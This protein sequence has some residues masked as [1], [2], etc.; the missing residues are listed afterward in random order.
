VT[1]R[2]DGATAALLEGLPEESQ[3]LSPER[4]HQGVGG[5]VLGLST[6]RCARAGKLLPPPLHL[7]LLML[8]RT[9]GPEA[10]GALAGA[11]DRWWGADLL[12]LSSEP[13]ARL[14]RR[15]L[16]IA[17]AKIGQPTV[18]DL[19][20][21]HQ[22]LVG[23]QARARAGR[24]T[25]VP[26]P[27]ARRWGVH[28][29]PAALVDQVTT[30]TLEPLLDGDITA[31]RICDPAMGG[32]AFLLGA[33]RFLAPRLA[34]S[35][36]PAALRSARRRIAER[37]LFGADRD[38]VAAWLTRMS[39]WLAVGDPTLTPRFCADHIL[40][41]DA[42]R[43]P[44]PELR[45]DSWRPDS[46]G[47]D[48]WAVLPMLFQR[49]PPGFDAVL[50]NP[51]F[52]GGKR[53]STEHGRAYR[54]VLRR[55][56]PRI[57]GNA[58]LAAHFLLR[59]WRLL[60]RGGSLGLVMPTT[61]GQGDTRSS[62]LASLTDGTLVRAVSR[63]PWPGAAGV[64]VSLIHLYA[65][66]WTGPR[67]L[68][69]AL[70]PHIASDLSARRWSEPPPAQPSHRRC[71][72]GCDLKGLGF[73]F[74]DGDPRSTPLSVREEILSQEPRYSAVIRPYMGAADLLSA[75]DLQPRA[76]VIALGRREEAEARAWPRVMEIV[77][78]RV[79][80][81][82]VHRSPEVAAWRWWWWWRDRPALTGAL[83]G[84]TRCLVVPLITK[85]LV[86]VWMPADI[87]FNHKLAVVTGADD[88]DFAVLQSG[89]HEAWARA[90]SS[91]RGVQINYTPSRCFRTFPF[92]ELSATERSPLSELGRALDTERI[93]QM[94]DH[95]WSLA[96]LRD[97]LPTHPSLARLRA[98]AAAVDRA[99]L[100]AYGWRDL[101]SEQPAAVLDRL[102]DLAISR[103]A[104]SENSAGV[105]GRAVSPAPADGSTA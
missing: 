93:A 72:I 62:G 29:T 87:V 82:R 27:G 9:P 2:A 18:T 76:S 22:H 6:L 33:L 44:A 68:D 79:R 88:A 34:N 32:G 100:D 38:P 37:C 61:I 52:L 40:V 7:R 84:Q 15:S 90:L 85:H 26:G 80:P 39:L 78:R 91:T 5:I 63:M 98:L 31:L 81:E 89:V 46:E 58:D 73:L 101:S 45:R 30:P 56:H 8:E 50:G 48:W 60:R 36:A 102:R 16:T 53:I 94:T 97:A 54:A 86:W 103:S 10:L 4:I 67:W 96:R 104:R 77:E 99:V 70:V 49:N 23:R 57:S 47:V 17:L 64:Q 28:F 59:S 1:N 12:S 83:A 105:P 19:G 71:F 21:F 51:P 75:W 25:T 3:D 11:A 24:W 14:S 95:R 35:D 41:G 55:A 74:R 92:P 20:T 13:R 65:G 69:G 42:L 66:E 43:V